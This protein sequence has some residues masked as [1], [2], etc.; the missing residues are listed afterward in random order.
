M[1]HS[2]LISPSI[3]SA[4]FTNLGRDVQAM[5]DVGCGPIHFDVMDHDFVPNLSFGAPICASLRKAGFTTPI[6]AHLMVMQPEKFVD[7]FAK[8]G[9][10][11][12]IFHEETTSDIDGT[13]DKIIASGMQAGLAFNPDKAVEI[14]P[15]RLAKLSMILLMS[16]FPGFGGQAFIDGVYEK[17]VK[18]RRLIEANNSNAYLGVD[19]GVKVDNIGKVATAGADMLIVGSGLFGADNYKLRMDELRA[20]I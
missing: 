2:P 7:E 19:G 8:A 17:I 5:I 4:D 18:T 12:L 11:M 3:L 14:P 1:S 13:I 20:A 15:K 9:A 6:E 10:N 16:V